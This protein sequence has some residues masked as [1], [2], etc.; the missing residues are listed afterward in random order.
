MPLYNFKKKVKFYVVIDGLKYLVD[1][2]P[3]VSFS[4]TF[5]ESSRKVKTLHAQ[6]NMFDAAIINEANPVNFDF[7]MPLYVSLQ[8]KPILALLID[9]ANSSEVTLKTADIYVDTDEEIFKLEKAVFERGTFNINRSNVV[10][11]SISGSASKLTKFGP[12]G[13]IIPGS[14]QAG[15]DGTSTFLEPRFMQ[16]SINGVVQ[17]SIHSISVEIANDVEW[18]PNNTL[19]KSLVVN[20]PSDTTYPGGF[21]VSGRTV[22][23]IVQ[24]YLTDEN[25]DNANTWAISVPLSI[26]IA[27]TQGIYTLKFTFPEVV[28]TN[29]METGDL[30]LQNYDYR[31]TSNPS[32]LS[33]LITY[34]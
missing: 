29:R 3:D 17:S 21:V 2:Y 30:F 10:S 20:G 5:K 6:T 13:T 31:L 19:H 7:T 32:D 27:T 11:V 25:V 12:S 28:Y 22:S 24:Q 18:L 16:V 14:L 8:I 33:T 23:G 4:Q 1:I 15:T 34:T 26:W 9:Y